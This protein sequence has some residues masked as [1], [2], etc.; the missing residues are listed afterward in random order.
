[1][2]ARDAASAFTEGV[3]AGFPFEAG[4]DFANTLALAISV[5]ARPM[6]GGLSPYFI[7]RAPVAA[8]NPKGER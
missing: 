7:I 6:L 5:L 2:S 8:P 4:P 3:L 1:M